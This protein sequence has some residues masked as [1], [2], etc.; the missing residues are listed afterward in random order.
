[1]ED[2]RV[3]VKERQEDKLGISVDREKRWKK[4]FLEDI[5]LQPHYL[6]RE[7]LLCIVLLCILAT[8]S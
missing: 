1:M 4:S 2:C 5:I 7:D 3:M 8:S 6:G